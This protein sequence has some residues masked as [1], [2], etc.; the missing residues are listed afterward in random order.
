M[1]TSNPILLVVA[2][3]LLG[4]F[5]LNWFNSGQNQLAP[6]IAFIDID[7]QEHSL[8]QYAQKPVLMIFWATDCPG[9]VQ[10]MPELNTLHQD[11]AQQGLTMIGVAMPHDRPEH[12][13]AMRE[14]RQLPYTLTWDKDGTIAKAFN[15]VR[16][17]PTHFLIAPNGE[18]VMRKI[19]ELNFDQ[20]REK[21]HGMGLSPA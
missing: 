14:Q 16:V 20:L 1:K 2:V 9:C 11:Y 5:T 17:T 7:G 13:T 12:I 8:T 3:V 21:L 18:I 19:G 15:N 10:E 4:F 6:Q